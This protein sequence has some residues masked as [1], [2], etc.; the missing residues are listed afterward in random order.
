MAANRDPSFFPDPHRFDISRSNARQ[1]VTFVHGPHGCIGAHLTRMETV[2][3][4]EAMADLFPN[5]RLVAG[6]STPPA[7]F[8]FRK[9]DRVTVELH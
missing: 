3:A 1:H 7:G 6:A 4:I 9:P 5:L 8:I 2:A